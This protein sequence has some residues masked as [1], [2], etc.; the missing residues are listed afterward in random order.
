MT[1]TAFATKADLDA[2]LDGTRSAFRADLAELKSDLLKVAIGI[3]VANV[4]LTVT[5]IK[6]L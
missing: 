2:A 6:L 5:L 1:A 4:G 3:V